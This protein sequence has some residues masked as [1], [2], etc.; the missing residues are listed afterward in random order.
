MGDCAKNSNSGNIIFDLLSFDIKTFRTD[1]YK[2]VGFELNDEDTEFKRY[3]KV[4]DFPELGLFKTLDVLI[5][6]ENEASYFFQANTKEI[7]LNELENLINKIFD[8]YGADSMGN[9][10]LMDNELSDIMSGTYWKGRMWID[11][12]PEIMFILKERGIVE[13]GILGIDINM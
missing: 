9:G 7:N 8:S 5:F 11:S 3:R 6:S 12:E 13:L 4:L 1:E 2:F 10:K